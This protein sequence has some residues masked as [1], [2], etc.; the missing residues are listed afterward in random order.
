MFERFHTEDKVRSL[1][2]YN[3]LKKICLTT[4]KDKESL[5]IVR[6]IIFYIC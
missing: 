2:E 1:K 5:F 3:F 6:I 4:D